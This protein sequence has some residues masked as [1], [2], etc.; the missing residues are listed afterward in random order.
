MN[1]RSLRT[2]RTEK[3]KYIKWLRF[4]M[5]LL[6]PTTFFGFGI[7]LLG[8]NSWEAECN[9]TLITCTSNASAGVDNTALQIVSVS[10]IARADAA[11]ETTTRWRAHAARIYCAVGVK[12]LQGM[13]ETVIMM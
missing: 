12:I 8:S 6:L 13:A 1:K 4:T 3:W 7:E 11:V 2:C 9:L 5:D 10:T